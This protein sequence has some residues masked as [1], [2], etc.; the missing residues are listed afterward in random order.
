MQ[1]EYNMGAFNQEL[2]NED[3]LKSLDLYGMKEGIL[4]VTSNSHIQ[5]F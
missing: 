3:I 4:P 1:F 5:I 2:Y